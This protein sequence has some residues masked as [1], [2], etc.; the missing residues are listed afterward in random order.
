MKIITNGRNIELTEAIKTAVEDKL[1]RLKNH[2]DFIQEIHV[3]LGVEKN[4]RIHDNQ[5]AE[6]TVHVPGAIVRVEVASSDLYGSIE[7]L[8]G[9]IDRSLK[10]H[11]TKLTKVDHN[12]TIR[13]VDDTEV[14][15][16]DDTEDEDEADVQ[17]IAVEAP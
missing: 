12:Q 17:I 4:P 3:I 8:S 13:H 1:S 9:K 5:I 14:I 10:K 7:A 16:F 11:K 6:A 15:E 2:Y